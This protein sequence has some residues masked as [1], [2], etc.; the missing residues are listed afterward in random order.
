MEN[1]ALVGLVENLKPAM[2]EL[3]VR[4]VIQQQPN[5]FIFQTRSLK[6]PAFKILLDT[7]QPALYASESRPPHESPATDFLM[8]LRK[9]L[10]S[11]ELVSFNKPLSERILEFGF[12][13]V[14]P[15]KELETMSMIVELLPNA[16]NLILLDGERR[17]L[18]SFLPVTP[19]H[20]IGEY[21]TYRLPQSGNKIDLERIANEDVPELS[22]FDEAGDKKAWLIANVAG[23]GPV[24]AN[25]IVYRQ[26]K[27]GR[28]LIEE[29]REL[30]AHARAI[31]R[32]AWLYT[33]LP[34]GHILESNDTRRLSKAIISPIELETLERS[35]SHRLFANIVEATRF[36]LDELESRTLLD[37][38]KMPR[39]R[40]LREGV[41]RFADREK[42]LLRDQQQYEEA[43]GLHKTA[44]LLTSSGLKM[45][46]HY[47]TVTVKDYFAEKPEQV[48]ID[49]DSTLS[50]RENIDLMFKR[51]TKATRGKQ[52]L[53]GRIKEHR[54]KR[55]RVEE[56]LRR[57]QA[58][59]DWDT[60]LA[61][62]DKL[63]KERSG[64]IPKDDKE[65]VLR[66]FRTMRIEGVDVFV[67]RSGRENDELTFHIA[68]ADDF[69]MHVADYSGSH[70]I[71]RNP[72]REKEPNPEV[73][74]KAAQLAAYFSQAR[75]S[76]K[77]EVHYTRRKHVVKPKRAKPGMV[78]LLEFKSISVEPK[79]WTTE[80]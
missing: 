53:V 17:V 60:W 77:V 46:Q 68:T 49:L 7:R 22:A 61:V 21:E 79:D 51:H 43:A 8:V 47:E 65:P 27:S 1:F 13:T 23:F 15:S 5:G 12:K 29:I 33:D 19:Q 41:K 45:E 3:I 50:L 66:R 38:A 35:H 2:A 30:I 14:V 36:Y 58:I 62:A 28:P 63:D 78:R 20:G 25:E 70:V 67:G 55:E 56:Q 11:A 75:N 80:K 73:L 69:W 9:H 16:P 39:I 72:T 42:K 48:K 54:V 18:S 44:Q 4:R 74:T 6:L 34:L 64:S 59:R 26:K 76:S 24:F 57:T 52:T 37:Q 71:V 10:T 31:S 32:S 40:E